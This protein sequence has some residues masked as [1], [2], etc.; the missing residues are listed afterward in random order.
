MVLGLDVFL[1]SIGRK[2]WS[3][4]FKQGLRG[5]RKYL[6]IP[7]WCDSVGTAKRQVRATTFNKHRARAKT[8]HHTAG[9]IL[10]LLIILMHPAV[11]SHTTRRRGMG[12][13][14]GAMA[15]NKVTTH[16]PCNLRFER[17]RERKFAD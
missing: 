15:S 9:P 10:L 8:T 16:I 14:V 5:T 3:E 12:N 1:A 2:L 11:I 7:W 6:G 4:V 13:G 17:E